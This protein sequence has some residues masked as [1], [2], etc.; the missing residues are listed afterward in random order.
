MTN[1]L[2]L[3]LGFAILAFGLLDL[4][5]WQGAN[6]LFLARKLYWRIDWLAF[7]R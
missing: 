1:R 2:A 6:L 3:A 5:L 4:A 7:W